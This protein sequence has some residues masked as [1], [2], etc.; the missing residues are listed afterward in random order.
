MGTLTKTFV[1]LNLVFSIVFVAASATVLSQR[2]NWR[3]QF[4]VLTRKFEDA[5]KSWTEKETDLSTRLE[6]TSKRLDT[7]QKDA[8]DQL[9]DLRTAQEML[10]ERTA[11]VTSL[12]TDMEAANARAEGLSK[13]VDLLTTAL[14]NTRAELKTFKDGYETATQN[15]DES[16]MT[17]VALRA[18]N[19]G[20]E[21][22]QEQLR[23]RVNVV[24]NELDELRKFKKAVGSVA[25]DV[26][27]QVTVGSERGE[28]SPG[29]I[30]ATVQAVDPEYGIVILNVGYDNPN[31]PP[32][33][34]GY[35]FLIHRGKEYVAAVIVTSVEKTKCSAKLAPPTDVDDPNV[36]IQVG[37]QAM[38]SY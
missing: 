3:E 9:K 30:R 35:R 5:Q 15:L 8:Q 1:V 4:E 33:K 28:V 6:N 34:K 18:T 22:G 38:I 16:N 27:R 32:V 23:Q 17:I 36:V 29:P 21:V 25:P 12:E 19:Q 26:A 2:S 24:T 7:V 14:E 13:N 20:L 10:A 37:D 31:G 11:R